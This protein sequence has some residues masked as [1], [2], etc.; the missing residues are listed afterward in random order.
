MGQANQQCA[1]LDNVIVLVFAIGC[2]VVYV[3]PL[4]VVFL[5]PAIGPAARLW[6]CI[7][8][9]SIHMFTGQVYS[10]CLVRYARL[11]KMWF[12]IFRFTG[13]CCL[14]Q[15]IEPRLY[16]SNL[17]LHPVT[18]LLAL[19]SWGVL[20]SVQFDNESMQEHLPLPRYLDIDC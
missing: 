9:I 3:A 17:D 1:H 5:D 8:P 14:H 10:N 11:G 12:G 15:V 18:I 2:I 13:F 7:V 6:A 4:P 19:L 16:G 20:W